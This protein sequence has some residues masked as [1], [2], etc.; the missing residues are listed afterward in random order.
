MG[1]GCLSLMFRTHW[2]G[3]CI[4][5]IYRILYKFESKHHTK[6][7]KTQNWK[8]NESKLNGKQIELHQL[9]KKSI[10]IFRMKNTKLF[11]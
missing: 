2:V 1:R 9:S 8:M 6:P 3:R 10:D 5:A 11:L 7:K 4:D